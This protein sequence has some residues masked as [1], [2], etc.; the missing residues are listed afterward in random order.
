ME[1]KLV[2]PSMFVN[3]FF[4][5]FSSINLGKVNNYEGIL[6]SVKLQFTA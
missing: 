5:R 3:L 1:I 4:D 2:I 6:S